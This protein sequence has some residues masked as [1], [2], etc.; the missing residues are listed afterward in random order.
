MGVGLGGSPGPKHPG[1]LAVGKVVMALGTDRC[2]GHVVGRLRE[3][4]RSGAGQRDGARPEEKFQ[5]GSLLV[6]RYL[7]P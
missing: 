2:L 3:R 4:H 6:H 1:V 5:R 7:S